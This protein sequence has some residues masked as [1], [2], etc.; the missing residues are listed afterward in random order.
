MQSQ[1]VKFNPE[2]DRVDVDQV[3]REL[4]FDKSE[5]KNTSEQS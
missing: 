5:S 1:E 2:E 3:K 4:K